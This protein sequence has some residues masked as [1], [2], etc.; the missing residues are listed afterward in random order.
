VICK[1][2]EPEPPRLRETCDFLEYRVLQRANFRSTVRAPV[3]TNLKI[4]HIGADGTK[5]ADRLAQVWLVA[6]SLNHV[7][8]RHC[9]ILRAA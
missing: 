8:I 4:N 1:F 3:M 6:S 2:I 5:A 7:E 9:Q